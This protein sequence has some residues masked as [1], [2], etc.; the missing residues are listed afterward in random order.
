MHIKPPMTGGRQPHDL[1]SLAKVVG[2]HRITWRA[3]ASAVNNSDAVVDALSWLVGDEEAVEVERSTSYHGPEL[4]LIQAV[5]S[6]KKTALISLSRL[7]EQALQVLKNELEDRLDEQNVLHIRIGFA[8]L[9][10]GRIVLLNTSE[11]G[12][13]KGQAKIE[14]YPGQ[15]PLEEAR[16]VLDEAILISRSSLATEGLP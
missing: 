12:T 3:T 8:E 1:S 10:D 16:A 13:V 2:L 15:D 5:S 11:T 4:A 7:G 9:I 14:V 6:K